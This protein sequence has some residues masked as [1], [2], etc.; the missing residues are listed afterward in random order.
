MST[1]SRKEAIC[2]GLV[3]YATG[4]PCKMGHTAERYVSNSR[5]VICDLTLSDGRKERKYARERDRKSLDHERIKAR[6]AEYWQENLERGRARGAAWRA[7]NAQHLR[8]LVAAWRIANADRRAVNQRNR[9]ARVRGAEGSHS[10]A[11]IEALLVF[12]DGACRYCGTDISVGYH[13]D[14]LIPLSRGGGNG[15]SNIQ[16]LCQPCNQAKYTKTHEEFAE[17]LKAMRWAP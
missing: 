14:H 3:R 7:S 11:E 17:I 15:I 16:L 10:I 4:K 6:K 13:A 8:D 2:L 5:C 12:Q 1:I 9:R